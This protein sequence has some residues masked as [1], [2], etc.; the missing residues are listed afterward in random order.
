MF[1]V[2]FTA[3]VCTPECIR[4][5]RGGNDSSSHEDNARRPTNRRCERDS[6]HERETNGVDTRREQRRCSGVVSAARAAVTP[7]I[8]WTESEKGEIA[9]VIKQRRH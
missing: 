8:E 7:K 6:E 5:S 2:A 9:E 1:A 3:K 4:R